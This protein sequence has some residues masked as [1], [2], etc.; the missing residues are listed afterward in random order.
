[1]L[2]NQIYFTLAK[3]ESPALWKLKM[4]GL[5]SAKV[6]LSLILYS[7]TFRTQ[8]SNALIKFRINRYEGLRRIQ[9]L[10]MDAGD[11]Q[12]QKNLQIGSLETKLPFLS[13]Q[14]SLKTPKGTMY[15]RLLKSGNNIK[16]TKPKRNP[17]TFKIFVTE[18]N[19]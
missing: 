5:L 3:K 12:N 15:D 7:G 11:I 14:G 9:N 18:L 2:L 6:N 13:G 16:K 19:I 4:I 1:M 10:S 8:C 17:C